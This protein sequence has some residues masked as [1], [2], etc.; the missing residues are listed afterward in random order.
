MSALAQKQAFRCAI[1]MSAL[2]SEADMCGATM[3]V[4][5]GAKSGHLPSYSITTSARESSVG[6]TVRPSVFAVLRLITKS[7]RVG[8]SIGRSAGL[9]PFSILSMKYAARRYKLSIFTP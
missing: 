8:C 9:L 5:F 2:P 4:R 6:G 7:N 3:D 1:G